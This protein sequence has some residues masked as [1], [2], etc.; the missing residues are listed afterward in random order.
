MAMSLNA[1]KK[2]TKEE[3]SNMVIDYQNKFDNMLSNINVERTSLRDR[4]TKMSSFSLQG[5]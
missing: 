3:L 4:F 1:L 5:E 2:L